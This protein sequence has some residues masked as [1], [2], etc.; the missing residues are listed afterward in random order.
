MGI[1][2]ENEHDLNP[3]LPGPV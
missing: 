2:F 3:H 1:I